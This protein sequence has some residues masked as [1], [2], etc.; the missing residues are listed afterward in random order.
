ML[1]INQLYSFTL[2]MTVASTPH[3]NL[4]DMSGMDI[5]DGY[6]DHLLTADS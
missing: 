5:R 1:D 6:C 2:P 3:N 4:R